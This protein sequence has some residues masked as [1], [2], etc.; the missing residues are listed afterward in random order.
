MQ[1]IL[2]HQMIVKPQRRVSMRGHLPFVMKQLRFRCHFMPSCPSSN[3]LKMY[4]K[5][6]AGI[7]GECANNSL[8]QL[9]D[10]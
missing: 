6:G 8:L 1:D 3:H 4:L 2:D 10:C 9:V 7:E 5:Y